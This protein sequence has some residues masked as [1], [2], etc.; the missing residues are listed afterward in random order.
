MRSTKI[1]AT[2]GPTSRDRAV[3]ERMIVAGMDVARLNFAHGDTDEH[4]ETVAMIRAVAAHVGREVAVLQDIPGPKLR[5]GPVEGEVAILDVGSHVVLTAERITGDSHRLPVAWPGFAELVTRDDVVYLADGAIRLRVVDTG[6]DEVETVVEVGGTVG[7]R[8]GL[9]L[10]NV[11]MSLPAVSDD[12]LAMIDAGIEMGVDLMALSFI[13]SGA[14]L[15]PV[16]ERLA[17]HDSDIPVIAKIEKPQA[18][19]NAEEI[20]EAADGI[21][22]ARGDL[23]IELPIEEVPLVQ[24]RL[25]YTAGQR[26]KPCITATQML[27][28]MVS[29]TRPTRAEVADVANAIFDGTDAV[30]LSQ[31]TAIGRDP[32]GAVQM[33]AAIA[34]ATER[35]L[36]YWR[37]LTERGLRGGDDSAAIAFGAVGAVYQLGLKALVCPTMTGKTARLLSSHRPQVPILALSPRIE[38]VRRCAIYWGVQAELNEEPDDTAAL[39]DVC[40]RAALRAGLCVPGDKIGITAGLPVGQAGGTNL[41]KVQVVTE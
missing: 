4:A 6:D 41:F 35:D 20:V 11:T 3:L 24:K 39:L 36:P 16:R 37:M 29:S 31:E 14:D 32:A 22:V 27:E 25:L 40:A 17:E 30:M 10:P 28:S 9:N 13:R 18:A 8:Q 34:T 7:S 1:V 23:G 15:E 21:M 5:I 38:T 2:I 33:M 12:D 19:A 26:A